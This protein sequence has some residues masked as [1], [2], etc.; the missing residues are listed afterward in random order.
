VGR[1]VNRAPSPIPERAR[2]PAVAIA[3][4]AATAAVLGPFLRIPGLV[5]DL[6]V[7]RMAN[8]MLAAHAQGQR[9]DA[10]NCPAFDYSFGYYLALE[11][12]L[13]A[14]AYRDGT[15]LLDILGRLAL[16]SC[17]VAVGAYALL[18]WRR[19]GEQGVMACAALALSPM[20][21]V[22]TYS[23]HP[24]LPSAALFFV[25]ALLAERAPRGWRAAG[26]A[27]GAL[28]WTAALCIRAD[29][30]LAMPWL[31]ALAWEDP[32][33][34]RTA[35]TAR[36]GAWVAA[37]LFT[38]S[39]L[40]KA[41]NPRTS[42][43][44]QIHDFIALYLGRDTLSRAAMV[45]LLGAGIVTCVVAAF[46]LARAALRPALR[47]RLV[48]ALTLVIPGLVF[49]IPVP[50]PA[51]HFFYVLVGISELAALAVVSRGPRAGV[52]AALALALGNMVVGEALYEPVVRH[53]PWKHPS[54]TR[55]R[56]TGSV[57][58]G[59]FLPERHAHARALAMFRDEGQRLSN[60]RDRDLLIFGGQTTPLLVLGFLERG[61]VDSLTLRGLTPG[62][63]ALRLVRGSQHVYVVSMPNTLS[64]DLEA[65]VLRQDPLPTAAV[66]L[67]LPAPDTIP[68]IPA[69]R[70]L[71]LAEATT[72]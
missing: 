20:A 60:F 56:A 40:Q 3:L 25:G 51:R 43:I 6:D 28:L 16:I 11:R 36:R 55:R 26:E 17:I 1:F 63:D 12:L 69:E 9:F 72:P 37:S 2:W 57:T 41:N 59:W 70:R 68:G 33:A 61:D 34:G 66:Y 15:V 54:V 13:P 49:W 14:S 21:L 53:Y 39:A 67:T 35:R 8:G 38:F 22:L 62:V 27:A 19:F 48:S 65:E 42:G 58:L 23:G 52:A 30:L 10:G 46:G 24:L 31:V 32:R 29:V 45:L 64:H 18:A 7:V 47:P 44:D 5:G 4:V 71:R 50:A